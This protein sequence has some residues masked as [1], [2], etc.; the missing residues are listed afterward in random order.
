MCIFHNVYMY[1]YRAYKRVR[2]EN[3]ND[4]QLHMAYAWRHF[5]DA[6][7]DCEW[8]IQNRDE[9]TMQIWYKGCGVTLPEQHKKK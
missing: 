2:E 5:Y 8:F 4:E 3:D 7:E 1:I 9:A 6:K